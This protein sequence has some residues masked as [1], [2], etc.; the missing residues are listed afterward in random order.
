VILIDTSIW[1]NHLDH[2]DPILHRLVELNEVLMH[3][4]VICEIALGTLRKRDQTLRELGR[5]PLTYPVDDN[6]VIEMIVGH[7]LHG[8]GIGYIDA[9]LVASC[10]LAD[11]TWLWTSDRRLAGVATR[12]GVNA[13][14]V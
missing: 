12:L 2:N 7:G 14:T 6:E 11:E 13:A 1:I 9:H 5:L 4:F 8:V 10:L 3:P